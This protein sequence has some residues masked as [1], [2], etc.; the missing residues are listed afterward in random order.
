MIK[1]RCRLLE[2]SS[3]IYLI[4]FAPKTCLPLAE[5]SRIAQVLPNDVDYRVMLTFLEFYLTLLKFVN[6]KLYHMIGAPYPPSADPKLQAAAADLAAIMKDMAAESRAALPGV[7]HW[8]C[9]V[10]D[11]EPAA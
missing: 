8:A 5:A 9:S 1:V 7:R 4:A 10:L 6:F 2:I 3:L 11:M